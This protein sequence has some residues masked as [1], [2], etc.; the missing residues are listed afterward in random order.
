MKVI[1]A[2]AVTDFIEAT[3]DPLTGHI[4]RLLD[5][6]ECHGNKIREPDSKALGGGLFELRITGKVHVRLFYFFHANQ[7]IVVHAIY[8]KRQKVP[9]RDIS[10]ARNMREWIIAAI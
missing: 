8:K 3:C 4:N 5:T 1:L 10:F 6:L 9:P 7:A 2:R